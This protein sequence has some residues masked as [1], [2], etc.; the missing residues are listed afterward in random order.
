MTEVD[1]LFETLKDN[2]NN[3]LYIYLMNL[4]SV[5]YIAIFI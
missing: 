2:I 4:K 3:R 1:E 5:F